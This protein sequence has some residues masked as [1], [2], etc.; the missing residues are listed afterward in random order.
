M[1]SAKTYAFES[2]SDLEIWT[3]LTDGFPAEDGE[4]TTLTVEKIP[5][6]TL[7]LYLRVREE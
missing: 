4:T 5:P 1:G 2:A 6:E 3:E 7:E